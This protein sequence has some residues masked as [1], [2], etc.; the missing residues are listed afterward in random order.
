[1]RLLLISTICSTYRLSVW[2][3]MRDSL[4]TDFTLSASSI[5]R[6]NIKT[7]DGN[8]EFGKDNFIELKNIYFLG[9]AIF[10]II[11]G[12]FKKIKKHDVIILPGEVSLISTWFLLL[13]SNILDKK[14]IIWTHGL[15]GRETSFRILIT[16]IFY[17]LA[18]KIWVYNQY[19]KELIISKKLKKNSEVDVVFNS[20]SNLHVKSSDKHFNLALRW[21]DNKLSSQ[22]TLI[23][24]GRIKKSRNLE[25][26][27]K[28][29]SLLNKNEKKVKVLI[30]GDISKVYINEFNAHLKLFDYDVIKWFP[31][32]YD[33][34]MLN[35]LIKKCDLTIYP[36][37]VG[38]AGIQ[39]LSV[40]TPVI[41]HDMFKL[42]KPEFEA[43]YNL[44]E[45]LFFEHYNAV[46]LANT[47]L[48]FLNLSEHR[49]KEIREKCI[50]EVKK[51]WTVSSQL[52]S[53]KNS[54]SSFK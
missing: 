23:F 37:G 19:S 11:P 24:F 7:F 54:L 5:E 9:I 6:N 20:N 1:M 46:S 49:R 33:T 48:K 53:M 15:Y 43:I 12:I 45:E 32:I 47:I 35:T 25:L 2:S 4:A 42:Q 17:S 16:N 18:D 26:L 44:H 22:S 10:Q 27:L 14:T 13:I 41:T 40:G 52:L 3:R 8:I 34:K 38:L 36:N 21:L 28:S 29:I 51:N 50:I 39:S 31:G 30:I